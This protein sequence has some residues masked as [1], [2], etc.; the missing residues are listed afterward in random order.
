MHILPPQSLFWGAAA[1]AAPTS[2]VHVKIFGPKTKFGGPLA[3]YIII[4]NKYG[5][6]HLLLYST[7]I[8]LSR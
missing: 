2:C 1:P 8:F 3:P 7:K 5:I 4:Y 6:S